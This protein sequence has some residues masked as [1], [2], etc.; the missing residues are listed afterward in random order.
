MQKTIPTLALLFELIDGGRDSV[1][2]KSTTRALEWAG[3]LESHAVRFYSLASNRT[4]DAAK[5]ILRRRDRLRDPFTAREIQHKNWAGLS[6]NQNVQEALELL[7]DHR[8]L[9]ESTTPTRQQGW[10]GLQPSTGGTPHSP[11]KL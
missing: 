8:Y 11:K 2:V 10:Q 1:G 7:V 6:L 4:M 9:K 3:Y 5:L